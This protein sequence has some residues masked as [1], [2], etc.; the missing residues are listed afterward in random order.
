MKRLKR[1]GNVTGIVTKN[2]TRIKEILRI[3]AAFEAKREFDAYRPA[4]K[5]VIK[6]RYVFMAF[7]IYNIFMSCVTGIIK[8]IELCPHCRDTTTKHRGRCFYPKNHK[9]K[10]TQA[11]K[12]SQ[13]I[14]LNRSGIAEA[15]QS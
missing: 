12:K 8:A 3:R 9:R 2:L 13:K 4:N 5:Q 1:R 14:L 7:D 15:T 6:N 10:A 11:K